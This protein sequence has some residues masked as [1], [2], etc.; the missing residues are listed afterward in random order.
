MEREPNEQFDGPFLVRKPTKKE[1]DTQGSVV[2][3]ESKNFLVWI[4]CVVD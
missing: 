2:V 1:C 3:F 4:D